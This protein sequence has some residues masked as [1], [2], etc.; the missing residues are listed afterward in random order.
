MAKINRCWGIDIGQCAIKALRCTVEDGQVVADAFD[1]IEYPKI[2]SQPEAEPEQLIR[3]ALETFL[4]RNKISRKEDKV[5]ISVPGQSGLA[6]FF[7]P[8]PVDT[9]KL[10]A[11]VQFEARQQIPFPLEE[12]IWDFERLVGGEEIDGF[13]IDAEVGL[14]AM[15][16]D[17]VH[18]SLKPFDKADIQL[19]IVQLAPMAIYNFVS[20]DILTEGPDEDLFDPDDPPESIVVLAMG[21]DSTDLVITNGFRMWQRSIPL[22]GN[23]FTKQLTKELKLTFAKAEHLKR[24]AR[25]AEDPKTVFQAMRPIFNDLVT[26]VQRSIGFFQGID[27]K[28]TIKGVVLLGNTV[29]L[30]GLQQYIAKNLG[31]DV[32]EFERFNELSGPSVLSSPQF[33]E[34][35]MAF[36]VSYGLCLQ[37]LGKARLSTSLLPR[38]ILTKRI[39]K[40]KKPWAVASLAA[41]MLAC[42]FNFFFHYNVWSKVKPDYEQDGETWSG[43]EEK[44]KIVKKTSDGHHAEHKDKEAQLTF[45][46]EIGE[47]V[48]GAGDRRILWLELMRAINQSLP[49]PEG[50]ERG[51]YVDY[52]TLP[53]DQRPVFYIDYVESEYFP[54]L[55]SWYTDIVKSKYGELKRHLRGDTIED[56]VATEG[57]ANVTVS[58]ED[59]AAAGS[60][61]PTGPGWVIE[62]KG[63]HYYNNRSLIR[64]ERGA[65]HVRF[66]F[67]KELEEGTIELPDGTMNPEDN[68][69]NLVTFTMKELGIQF[70][71]LLFDDGEPQ[72]VTVPNPDVSPAQAQPGA[73]NMMSM[74]G[75]EGFGGEDDEGDDPY[76]SGTSQIVPG[77]VPTEGD[78]E[79]TVL[80]S[81]Q[82]RRYSFT[83]QFCWQEI[84]LR[85]RLIALE[86]RKAKEAEEAAAKAEAEAAAKAAE[87]TAVGEDT[88]PADAAAVPEGAVEAGNE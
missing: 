71:L 42:S 86:E 40:A 54:T 36:G 58:A 19:D 6:K 38:E 84:R 39:I 17:Q 82:V 43:P 41:L 70:P 45:I 28:A 62:L 87:A 55:E 21:T 73:G 80:A 26:E 63:Y 60:E 64:N 14:F 83:I 8:P 56:P 20:H 18:R 44:V 49:W 23:H 1:Y 75:M 48:V 34:N 51:A 69:P 57:D 50:I 61:G 79:P 68:T 35:S 67:L 31:Y 47:E 37:G 2:L 85:D 72:T 25:Q 29:K 76:S 81:F 10:P 74:Q 32:I 53:M 13:L 27:R 46:K 77:A 9:K 12:V 15:K 24:N 66:S 65:N 33:A 11:I 22:G 88:E 16:R 30:P 52:K 5:A 4:S 7:K 3:D 78:G 59:V